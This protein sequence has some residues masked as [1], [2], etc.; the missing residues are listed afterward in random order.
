MRLSINGDDGTVAIT[1]PKTS[2][3]AETVLRGSAAAVARKAAALLKS[4]TIA[5]LAA[6]NPQ[7]AIAL[8][9]ARALAGTRLGREL[10]KG[11]GRGLKRVLGK[12]F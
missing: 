10:V 4:P 8:R 9:A 5:A 2:T 11:A 3:T 7:V 12:L 6:A 1:I